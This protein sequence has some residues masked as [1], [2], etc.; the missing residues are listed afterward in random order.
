[1]N[2]QFSPKL[3]LLSVVLVSLMM[4]RVDLVNAFMVVFGTIIVA[5]GLLL[6]LLLPFVLMYYILSVLRQWFGW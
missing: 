1:M 3:A 4:W 5:T 2:G 6:F